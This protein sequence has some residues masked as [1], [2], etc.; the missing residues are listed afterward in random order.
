MLH[1]PS[2]SLPGRPPRWRAVWAA[3]FLLAAVRSPL[4]APTAG[5]TNESV[6][7]HFAFSKAMLKDINENDARA[8][9]KVYAKN[10]GDESGIDTSVGPIVLDGTNAIAE[11]LRHRQIDMI[12]LTAEEFFAL[13]DQGLGG[14]FLMSTVNQSVTDEYVLLVRADG[15]VHRLEDLKGKSLIL[16]DDIRATLVPIWVAVLCREHGLEAPDQVFGRIT[17]A[18]KTTQVV[19]PVFFG[20]ADSCIT[21]RKG[22]DVMG[23]LNPQVKKQL[24]AIAVSAPLV[25]GFSCFRKALPEP[26]KE[27]L[28]QTAKSS[29]GKP[30]FQQLM[31]LFK[32]DA[33]SRQSGEMLADTRKLLAAYHQFR[34]GTNLTKTTNPEPGAS[35]VQ[36]TGKENR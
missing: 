22:W 27:R 5:E 2:I 15:P 26:L 7:V 14:P 9:M 24:R 16:A 17:A 18:S 4:A 3:L 23:E 8:A 11:A 10:I 20:K 33:L 28:L 13:E 30:S 19:L 21:T 35:Q 12:S 36:L 25:P 32:T 6:V 34:A 1:L 31:A 29:H